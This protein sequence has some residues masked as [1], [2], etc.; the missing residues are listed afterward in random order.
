MRIEFF[1][2]RDINTVKTVFFINLVYITAFLIAPRVHCLHRQCNLSAFNGEGSFEGLL[3]E[4]LCVLTLLKLVQ[5]ITFTKPRDFPV[6][7]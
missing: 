6:S 1:H 7:R 2:A 3:T 5:L 4:K